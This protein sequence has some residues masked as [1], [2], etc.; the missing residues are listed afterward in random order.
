MTLRR[1]D[2]RRP[3]GTR[4]ALSPRSSRDD[5]GQIGILILGVCVVVLTLVV[6]VVNVTAVQL[7]RVRLY[8]V[9]DAAALDAADALSEEAFYRAGVGP[10][11]PVTEDGVRDQAA[12]HLAA[13]PRPDRVTS[14]ALDAGTGTRDGHA[15]TV[16]LTGTVEVPLGSGLLE[17]VFGSVTITVVASAESRIDPPT[18]SQT[19]RPAL[20]P[21][22][23]RAGDQAF[24][25]GPQ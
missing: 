8:D 19:P 14:W 9:A 10:R 24:P 22:S 17:S 16:A 1:G 18:A 20:T 25:S 23:S 4:V 15:A 5:D 13:T 3:P 21:A 7:A 12:R 2:A 6:G 11:F